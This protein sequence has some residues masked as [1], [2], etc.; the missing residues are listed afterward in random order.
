MILEQTSS[1]QKIF[2]LLKLYD[3]ISLRSHIWRA[4]SNN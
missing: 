1:K 2:F 3:C 4:A